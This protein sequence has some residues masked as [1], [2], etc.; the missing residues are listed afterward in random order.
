MMDQEITVFNV[1]FAQADFIRSFT[2]YKKLKPEKKS[3]L[4][5]VWRRVFLATYFIGIMR[6]F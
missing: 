3:K 2:F 1:F 5:T 6:S 4:V